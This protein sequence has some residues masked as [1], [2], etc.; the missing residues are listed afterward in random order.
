MPFHLDGHRTSPSSGDGPP[1]SYFRKE[2]EHSTGA[3][4]LPPRMVLQYWALS[5]R[6]FNRYDQ[7]AGEPGKLTGQV[8][9]GGDPIVV[10][11]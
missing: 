3:C 10:M 11:K 9:F 4:L 5:P 6:L 7:Q 1:R 2:E 8:S